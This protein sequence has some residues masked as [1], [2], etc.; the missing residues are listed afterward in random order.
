[1][2]S[3]RLKLLRREKN[4]LQADVARIINVRSQ[5]YST[6]ENGREP[7]YEILI[8]LAKY[9]GV[10]TDFILGVTEERKTDNIRIM[11]E[12]LSCLKSMTE[13]VEELQESLYRK[14][15][16]ISEKLEKEQQK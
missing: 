6:Y 8:N 15:N 1:M 9:Y 3:K 2:F 11:E 14:T 16:E 13:H 10:S 12:T 4:V 7:S 5:T